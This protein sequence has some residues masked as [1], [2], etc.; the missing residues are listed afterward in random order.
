MSHEVASKKVWYGGV[1]LVVMGEGVRLVEVVAPP[2]RS[3][4]EELQ[5]GGPLKKLLDAKQL[6]EFLWSV[7]SKV[8]SCFPIQPH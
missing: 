8:L 7:H 1:L 5:L 6:Y 3:K 4:D 2:V